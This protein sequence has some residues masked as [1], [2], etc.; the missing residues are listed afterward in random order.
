MQDCQ[1]AL[2]LYREGSA[3]T[4]AEPTGKKVRI[5]DAAS[6]CVRNLLSDVQKMSDDLHTYSL[7]NSAL[8]EALKLINSSLTLL[9]VGTPLDQYQPYSL[10]VCLCVEWI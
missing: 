4:V 9:K 3:D 2:S 6:E 5:T 1:D 10:C 8:P 7:L